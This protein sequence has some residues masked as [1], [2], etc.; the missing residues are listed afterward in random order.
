MTIAVLSDFH[1]DRRAAETFLAQADRFDRIF[2]LGDGA[3]AFIRAAECLTVPLVAVAGNCD[4]DSVRPDEV[5]ETVCGVRFFLTHGHRHRVKDSRTA[6][7][8][9]ARLDDC[10]FALYGHTHVARVEVYDGVTLFNPGSPRPWLGKPS[11]G[12]LE[13]DGKT[14]VPK[15]ETL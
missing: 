12:V 3:E 11:F 15:I 8:V 10:A 5:I 14:F 9:R 1:G 7:A 6:L 13:Y 4:I 2:Y